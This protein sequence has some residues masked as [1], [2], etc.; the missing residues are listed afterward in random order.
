MTM[1]DLDASIVYH[2]PEMHSSCAGSHGAKY[3]VR[4][5]YQWNIMQ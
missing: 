4:E 2:V 1:L 5:E 3:L